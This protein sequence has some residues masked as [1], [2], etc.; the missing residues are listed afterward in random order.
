[1]QIANRTILIA[2][3]SS[4]LG[5]AC[6]ASFLNQGAKVLLLDHTDRL[7]ALELL[8]GEVRPP[9]RRRAPVPGPAASFEEPIG[10]DGSFTVVIPPTDRGERNAAPLALASR[11]PDVR[12]DHILHAI[13]VHIRDLHSP[14]PV[15]ARRHRRP[16][17]G[18]RAY[19]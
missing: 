16:N 19:G 2:G 17:L 3:G 1:M 15:P 14:R 7:A 10:I 5:A 4:G 13:A 18:K 6:A 9:V 12:D 11:L 8:L